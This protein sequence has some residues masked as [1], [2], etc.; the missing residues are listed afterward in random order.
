[1]IIS[2]PEAVFSNFSGSISSIDTAILVPGEVY[3]SPFNTLGVSYNC[4]HKL[5][6]SSQMT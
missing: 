4:R 1:M 3:R 2:L 6:K 5:Q